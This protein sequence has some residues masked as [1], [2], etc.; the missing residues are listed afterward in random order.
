MQLKPVSPRA[1][2]VDDEPMM[3]RLCRS[4]LEGMDLEVL[5]AHNAESA[6]ALLEREA[7]GIRLL[8]TDIRMG[9][10]MDGVELS[11]RVRKAHPHIEILIMS[12][13]ADEEPVKRMLAHA[14]FRFLQKPFTVAAMREEVRRMG[15]LW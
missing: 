6:L 11:H 7:T 4:I 5:E 9:T 12:G 8:L 13:Y 1:L 14:E 2:I 10:G 3:I 15:T